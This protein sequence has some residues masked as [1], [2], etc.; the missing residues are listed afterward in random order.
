MPASALAST[1]ALLHGGGSLACLAY[2]CGLCTVFGIIYTVTATVLVGRYLSR[3]SPPAS[4]Y[5]PVTVIKPLRGMETALLANLRSFCEQ[6]YPG[7]VQYLF[8]VHD[9]ADPALQVVAELRQ[10][11]P[12][13]HVTVIANSELHGSNRKVSNLLNMLPAAE[14]EVWVFADSDVTVGGD[15]LTRV[16]G[17]LEGEG[18]GLVTCAYVGVPDHGFW[19]KLSAR[20]VDYHFLP[21]VATGLALGLAKPC[22]GQAIAMRRKTLD[23][24]GGLRQFVNLLAEDHAIGAAVRSN[25]QKVVVP[26]FVVGHACPESTPVGLIEHELRWSR[27]IRRINP[28]GHFGSV[29]S[30]PVALSMLTLLAGSESA[31]TVLLFVVALCV[32]ALL[33]IRIDCALKRPVRDLWLLPL[34][35]IIAFGIHCASFFSSRVVWRG[36]HFDV[37]GQGLLKA[38]PVNPS[39]D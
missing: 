3:R 38:A 34:A 19:P 29:L 9:P 25:G 10:L 8:G 14:H 26:G 5:P 23:A 31:W 39:T 4:S 32:R 13:A 1:A 18:V 6:D 21:G 7:V 17:E 22:F 15:F 20:A 27:T 35:D 30:Y 2:V 24:I 37:D 16:I 36:V 33:Q 11:Y 28:R 12:D